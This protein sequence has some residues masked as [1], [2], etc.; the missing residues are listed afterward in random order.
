MQLNQFYN[1]QTNSKNCPKMNTDLRSMNYSLFSNILELEN[2][3]TAIL[4]ILFKTL[5]EIAKVSFIQINVNS[6]INSNKKW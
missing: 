1:L 3:L 5:S 6:I 4:T 2:F